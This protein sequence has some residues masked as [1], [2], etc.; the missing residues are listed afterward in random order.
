MFFDLER[1][2]NCEL[3]YVNSLM[4]TM[5][6]TLLGEGIHRRTFLSPSKRYVLKFPL[7]RSGVLSNQREH[8]LWHKYKNKDHDDIVYAPCRIIADTVLMMWAVTHTFG[9]ADGDAN[10]ISRGL[11]HSACRRLVDGAWSFEAAP[12]WVKYLD[13]SQAGILPNGKI[14]A[15]D[16]E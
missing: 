12:D 5:Q 6:F 1:V 2:K 16:Y 14:V 11:L 8:A 15:Y 4:K 13:C 9:C 10:A 3:N 7:C